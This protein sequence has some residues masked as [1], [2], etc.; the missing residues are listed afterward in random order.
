MPTRLDRLFNAVDGFLVFVA[1][2]FIVLMALHVAADILARLVFKESLDATTEIVSH[3]YMVGVAFLP[4]LHLRRKNVMIKVELL[5]GLM[6]ARV[7]RGLDISTDLLLAIWFLLWA[8]YTAG[9]AI[10][11]TQIGEFVDTTVDMLAIWPSRWL[12]PIGM[13]VAGLYCLL[14]SW[15]RLCGHSDSESVLKA[16]DPDVTA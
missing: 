13:S 8:W 5:A 12:L 6:S 11:K 15:R 10:H 7:I 16:A 4:L 3:Y 14:I 1:S 2:A 9:H